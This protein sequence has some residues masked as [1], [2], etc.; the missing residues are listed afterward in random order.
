MTK[1]LDYIIDHNK[2]FT[3]WTHYEKWE[4]REEVIEGMKDKAR[5]LCA[6]VLLSAVF[7]AMLIVG[8]SFSV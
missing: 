1:I 3:G 6:Y 2:A 7:G 4:Y 5:W 8:L